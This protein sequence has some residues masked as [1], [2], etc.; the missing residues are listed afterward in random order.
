MRNEVNRISWAQKH[1]CLLNPTY[2]F[3]VVVIAVASE[4][5]VVDDVA[6]QVCCHNIVGYVA[7]LAVADDSLAVDELI[8]EFAVSDVFVGSSYVVVFGTVVE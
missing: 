8:G 4:N 1:G 7:C 5:V 3:V 6:A 2:R